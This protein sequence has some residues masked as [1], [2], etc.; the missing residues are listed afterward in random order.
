MRGRFAP[1]PTGDLHF[2]NLRTALVA[3]L[4]VAAQYGTMVI[5]MEDLDPV[6][7]SAEHERRQLDDL[8][9]LGIGS[10]VPVVHQ[11]DRFDRYRAAI[12]RLEAAGLV[13]PCYC[14]RREIHDATTAP[15]GTHLPDGSYPGTC[16]RL[17]ARQCR[18]HEDAGRRP[19]LRLRTEQERYIV[20]DLICGA[21]TG[22][23][24][25]VVL[26]RNDG[27]PA[28]NLAVVVDD[29]EQGVTEVVRGDDLLPSTPRQLHLQHLLG[30]RRPVYA[31]VPLVLGPDGQR[32]AKRHGAVTRADWVRSGRS[33]AALVGL[34][35]GS[36]GLCA[37]GIEIAACELVSGF[38]FA[39]LRRS[40][41]TIA[42]A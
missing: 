31:H 12:A 17:T 21:Y 23:V 29:D 4:S 35:A 40:P 22:I 28:Y 18:A 37:E 11:S 39:R 32:L 10:D 24:D 25:D 36:L 7:S 41:W 30:L 16:R 34:L 19:A 42:T 33:N 5:R 2:G 27:I 26:Q 15:H 9:A 1:S 6:T 8:A 38:S 20:D 13:Y 14:T 3:W